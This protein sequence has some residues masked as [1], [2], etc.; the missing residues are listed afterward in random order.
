MVGNQQLIETTNHVVGHDVIAIICEC[1]SLLEV[2]FVILVFCSLAQ[3]MKCDE[4]PKT[5][6]KQKWGEMSRQCQK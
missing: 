1:I 3:L 4:P 6:K 5:I 2:K